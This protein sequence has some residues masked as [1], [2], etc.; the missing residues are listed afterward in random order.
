MLKT[1]GSKFGSN[2]DINYYCSKYLKTNKMPTTKKRVYNLPLE[3]EH[4]EFLE[5]QKRDHNKG[6]AWTLRKAL[7]QEMHAQNAKLPPSTIV[8]TRR[9]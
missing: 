3:P 2:V 6:F 5:Q 9:P 1:I 7:E 8:L 4:W